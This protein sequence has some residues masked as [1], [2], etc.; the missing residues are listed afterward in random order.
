MKATEE[1]IEKEIT[2]RARF[3]F[4]EFCDAFRNAVKR[5]EMWAWYSGDS[6]TRGDGVRIAYKEFDE[7]LKKETSLP[8]A[9]DGQF[10][11]KLRRDKE[12]FE[13]KKNKAVE[14]LS[15]RILKRGT[16]D[17]H[18]KQQAIVQIIEK[19]LR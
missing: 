16:S 7:I 6:S 14:E 8:T 4:N 2:D 17:Y 1:Q 10:Y 18:Q 5:S 9:L 11:E 3:R 15:D 12:E 19:M 13:K